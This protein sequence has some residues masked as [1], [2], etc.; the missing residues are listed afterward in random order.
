MKHEGLHYCQCLLVKEQVTAKQ[1]FLDMREM[2]KYEGCME[3]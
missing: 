2:E 3:T 1:S